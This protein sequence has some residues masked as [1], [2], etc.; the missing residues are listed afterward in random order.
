MTSRSIHRRA[1]LLLASAAAVVLC[2][3][4]VPARSAGTDGVVADP[5]LVQ[6]GNVVIRQ[7]DFDA[8]MLR[9][10]EKDRASFVSSPKRVRELID[11]MMMTLELAGTA[12]AKGLDKDPK[13]ARR[14]ELEQDKVLA[15]AYLAEVEATARREFDAKA[16]IEAAARESYLVDKA[17]YSKP[18][19]VMIS[20]INFR[21]DGAPDA[22]KARADDAYAK[23]KAGADMGDLAQKLSDNLTIARLR[24][25]RGPLSRADLDPELVPVVFGTAKVGEVN[26]P[27]RT[28]KNWTIV[29][30]NERIPASTMSFDDVKGGIIE[31]MRDEYIS[32]ARDAALAALGGGQKAIVNEAAIE[33]LQAPAGTKN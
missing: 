4:A 9:V 19:S 13:L 30:V 8:E 18:E 3:A 27:V 24:G 32:H 6:R 21:F 15:Q 17:K 12:K 7:S 26:P 14:I 28:S 20:Q 29:R 22:A 5:I 11:R 33:A 16:G 1:I 2:V 10:P 31:R 25:I 23:L